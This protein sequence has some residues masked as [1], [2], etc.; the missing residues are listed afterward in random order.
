MSNPKFR[1]N[2]PGK[3]LKQSGRSVNL[4]TPSCYGKEARS[5]DAIVCVVSRTI[6]AKNLPWKWT[7][8]LS[9][10]VEDHD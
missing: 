8:K 3:V 10:R 4:R 2:G 1:V 6:S 7:S 9:S 5:A